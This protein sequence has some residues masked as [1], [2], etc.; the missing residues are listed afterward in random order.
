MGTGVDVP[1]LPGGWRTV[2]AD[3]LVIHHDPVDASL[4][5]GLSRSGPPLRARLERLLGVR[6]AQRVEVVLIPAAE[7]RAGADLPEAPGWAAGFTPSGSRVLFIRVGALGVYPDR[8]VTSIFAH[9][10]GHAELSA[11][12]A[13]GRLP[14]WFEEGACMVLARPWDLRDS[15]TLTVAALFHATV[16]FTRLE[17]GFPEEERAARAAYARSFA[18]VSWLAR[19][20]GGAAALGQVARR[21]GEGRSFDSAF[22]LEFGMTPR[23]AMDAWDASRGRWVRVV[24]VLTGT[25][26]L[27]VV[28][29]LLFMVVLLHMQRRKRAVLQ[30]WEA[31]EGPEDAPPGP[32]EP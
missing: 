24:R 21:M 13:P 11:L 23:R 5:A 30:R 1:S 9:E 27:W 3:G 2:E 17:N 19:R 7:T 16:P 28:V 32:R 31:E 22:A 26:T 18:L 6:E 15:F 25:T 8:D 12:A 4:A 14:R 29:T 10:L 20:G